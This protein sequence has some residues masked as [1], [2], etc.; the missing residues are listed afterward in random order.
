MQYTSELLEELNVL[1]QLNLSTTQQGIKVHSDASESVI[2]A[3]ARLFEKGLLSQAD[4]GYPTTLGM[5]AAK[6]AQA[7]L[8]LLK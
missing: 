5:E 3:T 1:S 4:G 8:G 6:H 2:A 7:L